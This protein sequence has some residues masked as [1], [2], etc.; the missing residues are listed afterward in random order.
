MV[1][2]S[3]TVVIPGDMIVRQNSVGEDSRS[4]DLFSPLPIPDL[5]SS[6]AWSSFSHSPP[7]LR[8]H[9]TFIGVHRA[10]RPLVVYAPYRLFTT[11]AV[12]QES[13]QDVVYLKNGSIIRGVIIE[14]IPLVS[15]KIRTADGSVF[16][17]SMNDVEKMTRESPPRPSVQARHTPNR[18]RSSGQSSGVAMNGLAWLSYEQT[19]GLGFSYVVRANYLGVK[20][21]DDDGYRFKKTD[22]QG[23]GAG[24]S[25]RGYADVFHGRQAAFSAV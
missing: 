10:T 3:S 20:L 6:R 2:K 19:L 8:P 25:L 7:P 17:F 12:A 18:H 4:C 15:L 11:A 13:L 22:L 14:Q 24:V 16:V 23:F 1:A 21:E 9:P 5:T